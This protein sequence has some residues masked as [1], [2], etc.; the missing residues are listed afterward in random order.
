MACR[1]SLSRSGSARLEQAVAL[2]P[3]HL[4]CYQLTIHEGTPF[5][6]RLARGKMS[7]LPEEAQGD[8]FLFTHSFLRDHGYPGLRGLEFRP[9]ARAPLAAQPEI[10]APR[11]LSGPRPLGPLLLRHAPLVER[12]E[13][14]PLR[15]EDRDG[16][17]AGRGERRADA[18]GPRAR[19]ADAG[20]AHG[21]RDRSDAFRERYGV[22][23]RKRNEPLVERLAGEGLL[24]LE[25]SALI[26]T[27]A[28]LAVT[29]SL[30]RAFELDERNE[31]L[32][33]LR[34]DLH[35]LRFLAV[36]AGPVH[37]VLEGVVVHPG[38]DR[39]MLV[40]LPLIGSHMS[41]L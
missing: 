11:P 21:G 27:L 32:L 36:R 30:A 16:R 12:A 13:A 3:D 20:A 31:R 10:L 15:E 22:D 18:E 25:G 1:I 26:P 6:F 37:L 9:L 39:P 35:H 8:I 41:P 29:D 40:F 14:R 34:H 5:G 28:G 23:L 7:E 38:D 17:E 24:R 33:P 19:S 4:S 2:Q